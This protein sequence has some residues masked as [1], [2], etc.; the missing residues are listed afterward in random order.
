MT[1][2]IRVDCNE[3]FFFFSSRRRHTRSDRDWS[4]DV[5]SSDLNV[6]KPS[7]PPAPI[8]QP[9]GCPQEVQLSRISLLQRRSLWAW[10]RG[11][12]GENPRRAR[13]LQGCTP[14][15]AVEFAS[16]RKAR[17]RLPSDRPPPIG[18][19]RP[20]NALFG[21]RRT[22]QSPLEWVKPLTSRGFR[23]GRR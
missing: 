18:L 5:C 9:T 4:S 19:P 20:S 2:N 1:V 16:C 8:V 3:G 17:G 13:G 7:R 23:G 11:G 22:A 6:I 21:H 14:Q 12:D 15:A 10:G